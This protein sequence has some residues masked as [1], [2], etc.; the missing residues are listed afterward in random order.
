MKIEDNIIKGRDTLWIYSRVSSRSQ[1]EGMSLIQQQER[2]INFAKSHN[3]GWRIMN[4]EWGSAYRDDLTKRDVMNTIID[5]MYDS[6]VKFLYLLNISRNV[7]NE[8][9]ELLFKSACRDNNVRLCLDGGKFLDL[10]NEDDD[11]YYSIQSTF[12]R[13]GIFVRRRGRTV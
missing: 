2:G 12:G 7:R 11:L 3:M 9:V 6:K 10:D 1:T 8:N 5:G 4:E 13:S